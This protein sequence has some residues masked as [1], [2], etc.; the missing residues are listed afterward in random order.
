MITYI[1]PAVAAILG[2]LVLRESF[3]IGMAVGFLLV[4]AGSTLATR[5]RRLAPV[6]LDDHQ[7]ARGGA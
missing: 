5:R 6:S 2:V 1:N 7:A 4:I 3:T